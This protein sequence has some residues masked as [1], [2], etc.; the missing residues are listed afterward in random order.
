[1]RAHTGRDAAGIRDFRRTEAE[2]IGGAGLAL[3]VSCF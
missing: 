1:M 2:G 3:G